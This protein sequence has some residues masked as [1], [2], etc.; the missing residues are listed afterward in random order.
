[1]KWLWGFSIAIIWNLREIARFLYLVHRIMSPKNRHD[2][3]RECVPDCYIPLHVVGTGAKIEAI[4]TRLIRQGTR[5]G[6]PAE[7]RGWDRGS[8]GSSLANRS[9]AR[10]LARS[11]RSVHCR[12][13][14]AGSKFLYILLSVQCRA[15]AA[16]SKFLY[17]LLSVHCRC[18]P[19]QIPNVKKL[20]WTT[21][22][23]QISDCF[24]QFWK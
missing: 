13:F 5:L 17:K 15:F 11:I 7:T 2:N 16:R 23:S 19:T 1:M 20:I 4:Y 24:E 9:L 8:P 18:F 6:N 10:F 12:A 21:F 22:C 14:A 3:R